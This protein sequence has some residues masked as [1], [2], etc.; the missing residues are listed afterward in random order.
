MLTFPLL[1]G[2][3]TSGPCVSVCPSILL[4]GTKSRG[5]KDMG[6]NEVEGLA[7][8]HLLSWEYPREACFS[9]GVRQLPVYE[10]ALPVAHRAVL[11]LI[12][13]LVRTRLGKFRV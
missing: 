9:L 3:V 6:A 12:S 11:G 10:I 2:Y 13:V 5:H 4:S 7:S 8:D 1:V